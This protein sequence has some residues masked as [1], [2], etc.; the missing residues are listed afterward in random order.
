[1]I[2]RGWHHGKHDGTLS[3]WAGIV[4]RACSLHVRHKA[5]AGMLGSRN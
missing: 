4:D 2:T 3:N 1:M 5:A